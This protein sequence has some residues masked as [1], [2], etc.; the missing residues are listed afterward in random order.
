MATVVIVGNNGETKERKPDRLPE[1][2]EAN[3]VV[4]RSQGDKYQ[5]EFDRQKFAC[6]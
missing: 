4:V 3:V 2:Q 5:I 1:L 6:G